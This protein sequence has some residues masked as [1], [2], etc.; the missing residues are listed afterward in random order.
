MKKILFSIFI[1]SSA[2]VFAG[3]FG[4]SSRVAS[5]TFTGNDSNRI[6]LQYY[7]EIRME[8]LPNYKERTLNVRYTS[9]HPKKSEVSPEELT[10]NPAEE[11]VNATGSVGGEYFD[12]FEEVVEFVREY[13]VPEGLKEEVIPA[14]SVTFSVKLENLNDKVYE[15]SAGWEEG[16]DKPEF[17]DMTTLYLDLAKLLTEE[18]QV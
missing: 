11:D 2:M 16:A 5:L 3:C 10:Q 9:V 6:P 13:E 15:I 1:V 4:G 14:S 12:R 18:E 17:E 7:S 8:I